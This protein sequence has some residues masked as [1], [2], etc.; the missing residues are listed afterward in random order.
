MRPYRKPRSPVSEALIRLR[1]VLNLS[2]AEFAVRLLEMA[3]MTVSRFETVS[4][5]HGEVLLELSK[6]AADQIGKVDGKAAQALRWYAHY[7]QSLYLEEMIK[8]VGSPMTV[9]A[10]DNDASGRII[11]A[12]HAFLTIRL[13]GDDE[14]LAGVHAIA[15]VKRLR[16]K[17]PAARKA[18]ESHVRRH[19]REVIRLG[20]EGYVDGS[21]KKR[22]HKDGR[23]QAG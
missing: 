5:P 9:M 14:I 23:L 16:S 11:S 12:P 21:A 1:K 4:P 19:A 8:K 6:V 2:Q 22:R 7:F 20:A 10:N 17:D 15:L 3:P 18:A 13:D